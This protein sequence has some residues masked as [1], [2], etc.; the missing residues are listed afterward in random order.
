ML[1]IENL[2]NTDKQEKKR[3]KNPGVSSIDAPYHS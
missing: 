3:K 2:K 1:I